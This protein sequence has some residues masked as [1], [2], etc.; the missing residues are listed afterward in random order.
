[1]M[2]VNG[3][4]VNWAD[5]STNPNGNYRTLSL[6]QIQMRP[7]EVIRLRILNGT[8]SLFLP[9]VFPGLEVYQIAFDGVNLLAPIPST[10]D[11]T[12]TVSNANAG[13]VN[14]RNT[15][16]GNRIDLLIRA[17]QQAGSYTISAAATSDVAFMPFPKFDL[18]RVVVSGSPVTM[19]IPTTLPVPKREY[20]II[21]DADIVA[22]RTITYSEGPDNTLLT[23][24]GFFIDNHLYDDMRISQEVRVGTC[25][26]WTIVNQTG[27]SHPFHM[28][29]NSFQLTKINGVSIGT[30]EVWDTFVVPAQTGGTPGSITFRVRFRE[31]VGKT[32][33]H[34]HVLPHEDTGMMAN[35]MIS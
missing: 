14:V 6:P 27:E 9:L 11:Y 18:A 13:N 26:E 8:N 2:T 17:P 28:H 34:C 19:G 24:F 30:P 1:M 5:Y 25:E 10:F 12:G 15:S 29:V 31:F 16:P 7:G 4:G 23:G 22:R 21:T 33:H 20:P 35:F 3:V 32:V